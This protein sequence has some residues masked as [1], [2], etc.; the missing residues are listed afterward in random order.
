M[1]IELAPDVQ[2]R[3]KHPI[4]GLNEIALEIALGSGD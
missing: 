3:M 4:S 2:L 1:N